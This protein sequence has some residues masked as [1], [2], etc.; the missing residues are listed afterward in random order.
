MRIEKTI[1]NEVISTVSPHFTINTF[2][3]FGYE[4][5]G[6]DWTREI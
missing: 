3:Y 2:D 4:R 5:E 6:G 1:G